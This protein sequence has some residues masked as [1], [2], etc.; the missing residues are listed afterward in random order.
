MLI[1]Q[2]PLYFTFL[3]TSLKEEKYLLKLR[4]V[5]LRADRYFVWSN[6]TEIILRGKGV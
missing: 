3:A 1:V 6:D 5:P 4:A 2:L